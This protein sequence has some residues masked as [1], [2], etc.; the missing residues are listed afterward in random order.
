MKITRLALFL[1]GLLPFMVA[2]SSADVSHSTVDDSKLEFTS[3]QNL[4]EL[5]SANITPTLTDRIDPRTTT[6]SPNGEIIVFYHRDRENRMGM[7]CEYAFS[8][9][10]TT[11]MDGGEELPQFMGGF[12]SPDSRYVVLNS[13]V[14]TL[15]FMRESDLTIYDTQTDTIINR[16]DDEVSVREDIFEDDVRN[17]V[18]IDTT[19][20]FAPNGDLYFFRNAIDPSVDEWR[21]DLMRIPASDITGTSAPE[22]LWRHPT[23]GAFPIFRTTDWYLDGAMSISPDGNYLAIASISLGRP[24]DTTNGIWLFDLAE[25]AV[26]IQIP[27]SRLGEATVGVPTWLTEN[28]ISTQ[29]A[30]IMPNSLAWAGD[31]NTLVIRSINAIY[32]T[33]FF[34]PT[35]KYDVATDTLT[36]VYDF[37]TLSEDAYK[38]DITLFDDVS[39][40]ADVNPTIAVMSPSY[41]AVFY[42]GRDT[43]TDTFVLS[44]MSVV[45][46]GFATPRRIATLPDYEP[47]R[48]TITSIGYTS[49]ILR[50]STGTQLITLTEQ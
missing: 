9:N 35:Y 26:K 32:Y 45:E 20:I 18:W 34:V 11:C 39:L 22:V 30:G 3:I 37:T 43:L 42:I 28:M 48:N 33:E 31:S 1:I 5:L 17:R 21:A 46:S 47:L 40:F 27:I 25:N 38:P 13:D 4:E 2:H 50:I 41:Q 49:P 15:Q 10:A 7:V 8:A 24:D 12:W 44:A 29:F 16:T 19:P 36:S 6:L 23:I 14:A